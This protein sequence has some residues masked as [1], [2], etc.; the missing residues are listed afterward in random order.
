MI[1]LIVLAAGE[2][3]RFDGIKQLANFNQQHLINFQL[4]KLLSL[5]IPVVLVL[6]YQADY[7]KSQILGSLLDKITVI[8]NTHWQSG[9]ASSIKSSIHYL[10][11]K[12][13]ESSSVLFTLLD[14]ALV[15]RNELIDLIDKYKQKP[16]QI[17]SSFYDGHLGCPAI[18]PASYFDE[19]L[20]LKGDQGALKIIKSVKKFQQ[21]QIDNAEFDIDT[22]SQLNTYNHIYSTRS[23]S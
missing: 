10:K 8:E 22:Q 14:Q 9:L 15:T 17:C 12:Q 13:P 7:I 4:D 18:F 21:T 3:S 19:L 1:S 2:G 6:G 5:N 11:D 23:L 16:E 20:K